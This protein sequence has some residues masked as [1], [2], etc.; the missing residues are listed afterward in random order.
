MNSIVRKF[1]T[2]I[3][4]H[5]RCGTYLK[6]KE[7]KKDEPGYDWDD[8]TTFVLPDTRTHVFYVQFDSEPHLIHTF[9]EWDHACIYA[10][11]QQKLILDPYPILEASEI[12]ITDGYIMVINPINYEIYSMHL[13]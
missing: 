1:K 9:D 7:T 11:H 12:P 6:C 13:E 4:D 10:Q 8:V 2:R 5:Y 3:V